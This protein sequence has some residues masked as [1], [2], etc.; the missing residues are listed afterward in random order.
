MM[1]TSLM[2][3]MTMIVEGGSSN[4]KA[5]V[6]L[7]KIMM[8]LMTMA[9]TMMMMM[10]MMTTKELMVRGS[11]Y[12]HLT[13]RLDLTFNLVHSLLGHT[14]LDRVARVTMMMMM[15]FPIVFMI[16]TR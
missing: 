8:S 5:R 2:M 12:D 16:M 15:I 7:M 6:D 1:V 3:M 9:I 14:Q 4:C 13:V 10:V 11:S